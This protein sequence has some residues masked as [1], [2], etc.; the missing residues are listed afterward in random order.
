M[1]VEETP[2]FSAAFVRHLINNQLG[3]VS[4]DVEMHK[5]EENGSSMMN[6]E[7][8]DDIFVSNS[9]SKGR[10]DS[11]KSGYDDDTSQ[12]SDDSTSEICING[13]EEEGD[14]P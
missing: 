6:Q 8:K 2:E 10:G 7:A 5:V 12:F 11:N 4:Q 14:F 3:E 1:Q 9:L 13:S